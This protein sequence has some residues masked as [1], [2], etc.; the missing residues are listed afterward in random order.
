MQVIKAIL[1]QSSCEGH[2]LQRDEAKSVHAWLHS[3]PVVRVVL[4]EHIAARVDVVQQLR[5]QCDTNIVTTVH[6][7]QQ[8]LLI[9]LSL[10][11]LLGM[12]VT[13]WT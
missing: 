1:R 8:Y 2:T 4:A 11:K 12:M 6:V 3:I 10:W 13:M 7:P 9:Q 5:C